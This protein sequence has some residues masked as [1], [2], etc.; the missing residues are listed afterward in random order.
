MAESTE[1]PD[2]DALL[3]PACGYDLRGPIG[4]RCPECGLTIDRTQLAQSRLPWTHRARIGRGRA[5]WRTNWLVLR[6]AKVLASEIDR[7]VDFRA[8]QTFRR[9]TVLFAFIPLLGLG[10]WFYVRSLDRSLWQGFPTIVARAPALPGPSGTALGWVLEVCCLAAMAVALWLF[11]LG[12]A[13]VASYFYHPRRLPV[14]RQ[15]RAVAL[16][17]YTCA[18]VA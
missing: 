4:D 1:A 6:Q 10:I 17:Y 11:L 7:P 2:G 12:A 14:V 13:G 16:S 5:Y 18:P 9:M 3:C 15:N 8:A